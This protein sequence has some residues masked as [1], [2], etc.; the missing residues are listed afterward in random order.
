[1]LSYEERRAK[2]GD[3]KKQNE[4]NVTLNL[5]QTNYREHQTMRLNEPEKWPAALRL[6]LF[7]RRLGIQQSFWFRLASFVVLVSLSI[8]IFFKEDKAWVVDFLHS[9]NLLVHEAGHVVFRIFGNDV[10]TSMGGSLFQCMV[11]LIFFFALWIKPRD[12]FGAAVALWWSFEN[13]MD[14]VPYVADA[15]PMKLLL[16][17]GVTGAET[18]YGGHDWN[19]ILCELGYIVYYEEIAHAL[20]VIA[21]IGIAL[22]I[23]WAAWSLLYYWFVQ[24][25]MVKNQIYD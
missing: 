11:P 9:I 16:I 8:P 15:L 21:R 22:C 10:I 14:V 4:D 3:T 25:S 1:M 17:N 24:R 5:V 6:F 18:P 7:P 13:V 23:M 2:M 19:F 12:L 20:S